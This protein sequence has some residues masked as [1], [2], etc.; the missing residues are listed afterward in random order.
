M[1]SDRKASKAASSDQG[2]VIARS[3]EDIELSQ[4]EQDL[5]RAK[6]DLRLSERENRDQS[7]QLRDLKK[8]AAQ[9]H[10]RNGQLRSQNAQLL[11]R[12]RNNSG[13]GDKISKNERSKF[14]EHCDMLEDHIAHLQ[15]DRKKRESHME[16][17]TEQTREANESKGCLEAE[18][19]NLR[20]QVRD[21][22]TN[23]TECKD[24]LLRLQPT[25]QVSDNEIAEAYSNLDQQITAWVDDKTED[26]DI[27]EDQFDR[28]SSPEDLPDLF[29]GYVTSSHLRMARKYPGSQP[30][31]LRYLI[32]CYL[33]TFVLGSDIYLFGL[34]PR[35]IALFQG[36][37]EG[38]KL[39]E[40]RRGIEL[41]FSY[42]RYQCDGMTDPRAIDT[43]SIARWRTETLQA[44][45][46]MPSFLTEQ[47]QQ[48]ELLSQTLQ[49]ALSP[50]T[51]STHADFNPGEGWESLH[52]QIVLPALALHTKLRLSTSSTYNFTSN[53]FTNRDPAKRHHVFIY[54]AK[55][56]HFIDISTH[57]MIRHDSAL[58]KIAEDGKIGEEMLVISPALLRIVSE[59]E[60]RRKVLVAKPNILVKLDEPM[61]KKSRGMG[62]RAM[63]LLT[64]AWLGGSGGGGA[65]NS[66]TDDR[67]ARDSN[68]CRREDEQGVGRVEV[69]AEGTEDREAT[70]SI[71]VAH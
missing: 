37:E 13:K 11:D 9:S 34:D 39:L 38:M 29:R 68:T 63:G 53:L 41:F 24:D 1:P 51:N 22:S 10:E 14:F 70:L 60:K 54:E 71:T 7:L 42:V 27:L 35:T 31:L 47:T 25:S 66:E 32:H 6:R 57:K 44:L 12:L 8:A 56:A 64:P 15:Y 69:E 62:M 43:T 36:L 52:T 20:R 26:S 50:L 49:S 19:R 40:P 67:D 23:L 18:M 2:K 28:L 30:T 48:A 58:N 3:S 21:L 65:E 46:K 55:D 61:M 17:L 33:N 4:L 16:F 59:G 45:L 5:E